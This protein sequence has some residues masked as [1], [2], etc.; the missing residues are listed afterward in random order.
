MNEQ[1]RLQPNSVSGN[2]NIAIWR[3]WKESGIRNSLGKIGRGG[4]PFGNAKQFATATAIISSS[5]RCR[6]YLL[7]KIKQP[8]K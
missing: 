1:T 2:C 6:Y 3:R 8:S 7:A 4:V 5:F